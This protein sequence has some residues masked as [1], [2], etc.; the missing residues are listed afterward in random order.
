MR[1][2][3]A[4]VGTT[5]TGRLGGPC[6]SAGARSRSRTSRRPFSRASGLTKGDVMA[7]YLDVA[8]LALNHVARRPMQMKRY[9]NGVEGAFFYQ[10]RWL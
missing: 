5:V 1:D 10:K 6:G 2:A 7:Y 9:P 4:P 3:E 8:P